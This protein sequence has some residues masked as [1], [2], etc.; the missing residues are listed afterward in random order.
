M[1]VMRMYFCR[2]KGAVPTLIRI[3]YGCHIARWIYAQ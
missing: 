1:K 3:N 2:N